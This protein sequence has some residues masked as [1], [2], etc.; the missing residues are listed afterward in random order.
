MHRN[1][2]YTVAAALA[3]AMCLTTACSEND[4][5]TSSY[6]DYRL[7][8]YE[9]LMENATREEVVSLPSG[10]QYEVLREG[11]GK[12]P[13]ATDTVKCHY[14][15]WL[16]DGTVFDS[17]YDNG[18]PATFPLNRVISG[19][20]EGLQL[21]QEGSKHRLYI[22]YTLGYGPNGYASIPPFA[23]LIFDVELIE[24]L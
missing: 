16:I 14:K 13:K 22:P 5:S 23:T 6:D 24:V 21:M 20:T 2:F 3:A 1:K 9:Y 15:G 7:K 17:S 8:C 18:A 11:T 12:T 4:D 19:W 10:L